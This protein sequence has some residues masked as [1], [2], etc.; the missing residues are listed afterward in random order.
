MSSAREAQNAGVS[1]AARSVGL[2]WKALVEPALAFLGA[3]AFYVSIYGDLPYHD[4]ERFVRQIDGGN[5]VWDIGHIF[6]QPATLL[7]HRYLGA[8]EP[9][10]LSQKHINTFATGLAVAIFYALQLRLRVP[11]W[12]RIAASVLVAASCSLVTLAPTA[13][14]K[15]LAFPFMNASLYF[16]VVWERRAHADGP[17]GG[18]GELIL[19]AVLMA[20]AAAFL[21][22]CLATAPFTAAA[23][24]LISWRAGDRWTVSLVRAATFASVCGM[25]FIG[26]ALF[27]YVEFSG[28]PLT[29]R[30][31]ASSVA[32]KE[33]LR[34][35]FASFKDS[36]ARAVFSTANNFIAAPAIG[37]AARAWI[38]GLAPDLR[39]HLATLLGEG[40]P[41]LLT[42]GLIAVIY[43]RSA[44]TALRSG[45][46][47][48]PLAF[49]LGAQVWAVYYNLVD[50]EHWFQLTVPTVLLFLTAFPPPVV[51][52]VLPTWTVLTAAVNLA[53]IAL[54][55]ATY[56]FS[57][58]QAEL[59]VAFTPRD[60][61]VQFAAFPGAH[62]LGFFHLGT[63]PSL[64]LDLLLESNPDHGAFFKTVDARI[65]DTLQG[66]GKVVLFGVLDPDSWDAPWPGL[67]YR[68][69]TKAEL[70]GFFSQHYAIE[71][72]G[73]IAEIKAWQLHPRSD[74]ANAKGDGGR[75]GAP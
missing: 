44:T 26:L 16:L 8:G 35:G 1:P 30:G 75:A 11:A 64:K 43:L 54:P 70:F 71:P 6:M 10:E 38:V 19:A 24:L 7:W 34:V 25:V 39:S 22:S 55:V 14:M 59:R 12:Q 33:A 18:T 17:G 27:G 68:H 53:V 4:V 36:A 23:V 67:L 52:F 41:W 73:E 47:L 62:Y 5:Y 63:I 28:L 49:L 40:I 29:P 42:A 57:R 74:A 3:C 9:A 56:P 51:R 58:Y 15:L 2:E 32:A 45:S 61:L 60:L 13:H 48:V 31:L 37:S 21:A 65:A 66:G 69:M 20:L 72:L 46:C 50:P